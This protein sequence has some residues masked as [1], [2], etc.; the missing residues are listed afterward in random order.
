GGSELRIA[1]ERVRDAEREVEPDDAGRSGRDLVDELLR[2]PA[3]RVV[4]EEP[5]V[6]PGRVDAVGVP[7]RRVRGDGDDLPPLVAR[8]LRRTEVDAD[9]H[10]DLGCAAKETNGTMT[11]QFSPLPPP[12]SRA[13]RA[14]APAWNCAPAINS[15]DGACDHADARTSRAQLSRHEG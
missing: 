6:H 10:L 3:G 13:I 14:A 7:A 1:Q 9:D 2:G 12:W 8:P 11:L 4:R 5:G 15:A